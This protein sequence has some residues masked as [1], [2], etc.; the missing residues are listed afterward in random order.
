MNT[1][2][3][4]THSGFS[5]N[6]FSDQIKQQRFDMIIKVKAL[7]EERKALKGIKGTTQQWADLTVK[8]ETLQDKIDLAN[9]SLGLPVKERGAAKYHQSASVGS[10]TTPTKPSPHVNTNPV[11][12]QDHEPDEGYMYMDG[13]DME[14]WEDFLDECAK[15]QSENSDSE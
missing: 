9:R 3:K 4:K 2:F 12:H 7:R 13:K 10:H 15:T 1:E 14:S 11:K 8:I 5:K 6:V